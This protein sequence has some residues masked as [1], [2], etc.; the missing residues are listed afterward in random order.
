MKRPAGEKKYYSITEVAAE[1]E[2]NA[3]LLRY[4]ETVLPGIRPKRSRKG[5]RFYTRENIDYLK[6]IHSLV[7]DRGYTLKAVKE[8]LRNRTREPI[9]VQFRRT[10]EDMRSFL[11]DLRKELDA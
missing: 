2:V 4:W 10:L 11:T 9:Q 3:S 6:Q 7:K 5:T 8:Q 1:L